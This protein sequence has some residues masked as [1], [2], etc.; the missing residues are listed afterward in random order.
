MPDAIARNME[1][2]VLILAVC[3]ILLV[4]CSSSIAIVLKEIHD[5]VLRCEAANKKIEAD[6]V[7]GLAEASSY[8]PKSLDWKREENRKTGIWPNC[9][10]LSSHSIK[11]IKLGEINE[12]LESSSV[13]IGF[14]YGAYHVHWKPFHEEQNTLDY[15]GS[16]RAFRRDSY[17]GPGTDLI[18]VPATIC[19][20]DDVLNRT[21]A[22]AI[23][24]AVT[25]CEQG[26]SKL[27][28]LIGEKERESSGL[29][30][31]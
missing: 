23:M 19:G 15:A 2:K 5:R 14:D 17:D 28:R 24:I 27:L 6:L 3:L 22:E 20:I 8:T 11:K 25:E 1:G 9:D 21:R 29:K 18:V 26:K 12:W 31:G 13:S 4:L 10:T 16:W 30:E 7:A